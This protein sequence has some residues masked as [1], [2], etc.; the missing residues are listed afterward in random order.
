MRKNNNLGLLISRITIAGLMLFHGFAKLSSLS[1]IKSML[2]EAGLP[3]LMA[4][5]VYMTEIVAPLL[6]LI[7]FRIR[8]ASVVF[9]FG[10]IA[11]ML[12]AHSDAIF[13]ISKT[14]GLEVELILLYAF[15]ALVYFFTGAGT[16]AVSRSNK[17]D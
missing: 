3:E 2:A 5:G 8:L 6:I 1:G 13:A 12:L 9:F 4:Y 14:G 15:G 17:W 7:G 11:A 10:M 16:Y